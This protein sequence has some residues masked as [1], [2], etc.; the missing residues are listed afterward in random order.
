[1]A[2][3]KDQVSLFYR[4]SLV[5]TFP[6]KIASE[7]YSKASVNEVLGVVNFGYMRDNILVISR[8]QAS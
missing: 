3:V 2:E 4:L 6:I 7:A 1:M 5:G 8:G